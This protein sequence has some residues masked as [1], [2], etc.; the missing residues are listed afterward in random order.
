MEN[1]NTEN[2]IKAENECEKAKTILSVERKNCLEE[3]LRSLNMLNKLVKRTSDGKN[4][5]L[6]VVNYGF[7]QVWKI[8]FFPMK[9]DGN[10]SKNSSGYISSRFIEG[11]FAIGDYRESLLENFE[12][13]E[14]AD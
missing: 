3:Q 2:L 6:C 12:V 1:L 8:V 9:K 4:G 7:N 11:T 10:L 14:E 5:K 13:I